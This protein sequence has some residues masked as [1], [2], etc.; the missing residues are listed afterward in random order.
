[1]KVQRASHAY[2]REVHWPLVPR[3]SWSIA[4]KRKQVSPSHMLPRSQA[5]ENGDGGIFTNEFVWDQPHLSIISL[6]A[7][8]HHHMK[9]APSFESADSELGAAAPDRAQG[10][11]AITESE[12]S[13]H[14]EKFHGPRHLEVDHTPGKSTNQI[15]EMRAFATLRFQHVFPLLPD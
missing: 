8:L 5:C 11:I 4:K 10:I 15:L 14:R 13:D 1:M 9:P 7:S 12:S 3:R 6:L 2:V